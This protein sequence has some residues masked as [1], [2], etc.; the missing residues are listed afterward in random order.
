MV[1][2]VWYD[3]F[4]LVDLFWF[5]LFVFA[6]IF[7]LVFLFLVVFTLEVSFIFKVILFWVDGRQA[8]RTGGQP[9]G[10]TETVIIEL[11]QSS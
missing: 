1:D 4:A 10:W 11:T 8:S 5:G 3:R 7:E 9:A 2:L 6:F